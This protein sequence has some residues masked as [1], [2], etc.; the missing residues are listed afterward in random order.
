M[1]LYYGISNWT[2]RSHLNSGAKASCMRLSV[3]LGNYPGMDVK[4]RL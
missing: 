4:G 1:S 3:D 2:E